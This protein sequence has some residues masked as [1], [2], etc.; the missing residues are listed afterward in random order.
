MASFLNN[1]IGFLGISEI[2]EKSMYSMDFLGVPTLEDYVN[3]DL[4]T[5]IKA[6]EIINNG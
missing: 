5:R 3:T 2:I 4:E 1:E 6:K